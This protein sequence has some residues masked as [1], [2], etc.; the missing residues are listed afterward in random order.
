VSG[1]H[2]ILQNIF[3]KYV[4]LEYPDG[5]RLLGRPRHRWANNIRIELGLVGW[6]FVD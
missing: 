4:F 2:N 3:K 1:E 6:G 5:K